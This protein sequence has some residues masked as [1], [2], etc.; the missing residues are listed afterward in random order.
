MGTGYKNAV[1]CLSRSLS[2]ALAVAGGP[3]SERRRIRLSILDLCFDHLRSISLCARWLAGTNMTALCSLAC[4]AS[5][6]LF[7]LASL[8]ASAP[9]SSRRAARSF[10]FGGDGEE[11][12]R[13]EEEEDKGEG[14]DENGKDVEMEEAESGQVEEEN[15]SGLSNPEARILA[16]DWA[17]SKEKWEEAKSSALANQEAESIDDGDDDDSD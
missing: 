3:L 14:E 7:P 9:G 15:A 10:S 8:V 17:L 1:S 4:V 12:G 6:V 13:G 16:V 11:P 2:F 5:F